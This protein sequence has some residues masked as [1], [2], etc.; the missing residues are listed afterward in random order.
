MPG[1]HN[2]LNALAAFTIADL[3]EISLESVKSSLQQFTGVDRRFEVKGV[4]N[5]IMIIDDYAHHPS[6]IAATIS[7][8]RS[9][10]D[11][12]L[13]I[14][15]QPH[16][17]SRTRDF[18]KEFTQELANADQ[19]ILTEIYAAREDP[20]PDV[21]GNLLLKEALNNG[22]QH[23]LYI[24]E[25]EDIEKHLVDHLQSGD[26]IITM[27]AG[28]IWTVAENLVHKLTRRFKEV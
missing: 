3:I 4:V 19:V 8:A 11:R 7:A 12:N 5:D 2:I 10:W 27:G 21:D 6:E 24:P 25:K 16:L 22:Y 28:D 26:M 15:F 20:I 13:I 1:Q 14:V 23:F 9:G 17:Y 18:Y